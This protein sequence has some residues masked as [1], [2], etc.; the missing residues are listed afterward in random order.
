MV[1]F[2]GL[3]RE[4]QLIHVDDRVKIAC[5]CNQKQLVVAMVKDR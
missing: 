3:D 4:K 5:I 2:D 1:G